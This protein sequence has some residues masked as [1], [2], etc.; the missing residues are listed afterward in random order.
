M[1]AERY[2]AE[3]GLRVVST[4]YDE[5]RHS[6]PSGRRAV[7]PLPA[8]LPSEAACLLLIL[9]CSQLNLPDPSVV[10]DAILQYFG[11]F[12]SPTKDPDRIE[13]DRHEPR[14]FGDPYA[15]TQAL[16]I[17]LYRSAQ[18]GW[19]TEQRD[20]WAGMRNIAFPGEQTVHK[21]VMWDPM[22]GDLCGE[23]VSSG[24]IFCETH[25]QR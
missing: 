14:P 15:W 24:Y 2:V 5:W 10:S 23:A 6:L 18:Q 11:S 20:D 22:R 9:I 19:T 1:R 25:S 16:E 4:S 12:M 13:P 7:P 17:W 3:I 21:C 8:A